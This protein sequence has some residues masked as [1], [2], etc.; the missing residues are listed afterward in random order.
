MGNIYSEAEEVLVW[1]G[2]ETDEAQDFFWV[3]NDFTPA[4][5]GLPGD[6]FP[7]GKAVTELKLAHLGSLGLDISN[8]VQ[9]IARAES[10]TKFYRRSWFF[11]AWIVQEFSLAK[12]I[13]VLCGRT[14]LNWQDMVDMS[15][16]LNASK[17]YFGMRFRASTLGKTAHRG[18]MNT[19][20][21]SRLDQ[22]HSRRIIS[23]MIEYSG[24]S[25]RIDIRSTYLI[26]LA[27]RSRLGKCSNERDKIYSVLG[28]VNHAFPSRSETEMFQVDYRQSIEMVYHSAVSWSLEQSPLLF[29]LSLVEDR[30]KRQLK[31]LPSWIPDFSITPM[32]NPLV[33]SGKYNAPGINDFERIR[34]KIAG[35]VLTVLGAILD[36]VEVLDS[37]PLSDM[38]SMTSTS[39]C[40][41]LEFYSNL[42]SKYVNGQDSLEALSRT[43]IVDT[44]ERNSEI[45]YPA[46]SDTVESFSAWL[47]AV[48][49]RQLVNMTDVQISDHGAGDLPEHELDEEIDASV[50]ATIKAFNDK[51][52]VL[53]SLSA[54]RKVPPT[55]PTL[56]D[57]RDHSA[58]LSEHTRSVLI[59]AELP[60]SILAALYGNQVE[61]EILLSF[62]SLGRRLFRTSKGFIGLGPLSTQVSDQV[63]IFSAAKVPFVLR[64]CSDANTFSLIGE[65]Y[66]HGFMNGEAKA[67]GLLDNYVDI[68]LI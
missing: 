36:S 64:P 23:K 48:L 42:E 15:S 61:F 40:G 66:V 52:A 39:I 14:F 20:E 12:N 4:L 21:G 43:M 2:R 57:V 33:Y 6:D 47:L 54:A 60:P 19:L 13:L 49:G 29:V 53:D 9:R 22:E 50:F 18:I 25:N 28:M 44:C 11:R 8:T 67:M 30:S 38:V 37:E 56:R 24:T 32:V 41:F 68:H 10:Y 51:Y 45:F 46:P 31:T 3:H 1:L 65:A 59:G 17:G 35:P 27:H 62:S 63:W 16:F 34:S 55:L 26:Y 58:F 7:G 5:R